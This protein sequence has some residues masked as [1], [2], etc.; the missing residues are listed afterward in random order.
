MA[1][2]NFIAGKNKVF[3]VLRKFRSSL[4]RRPFDENIDAHEIMPQVNRTAVTVKKP[5]KSTAI[6]RKTIVPRCLPPCDCH[7]WCQSVYD[8]V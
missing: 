2:F 1:H 7:K 6:R 3:A 8:P 5:G 4:T